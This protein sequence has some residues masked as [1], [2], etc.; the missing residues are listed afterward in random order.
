[1]AT[2]SESTA[3]VTEIVS[4]TT[5]TLLKSIHE[6]NTSAINEL[7]QK[8]AEI[9]EDASQQNSTYGLPVRNLI[10]IIEK[11]NLTHEDETK[12]LSIMKTILRKASELNESEAPLLLTVCDFPHLMLDACIDLLSCL[13]KCKLCVR[14]GYLNN[15]PRQDYD[16]LLN[17]KIIEISV[18]NKEIAALRSINVDQSKP[19][20]VFVQKSTSN[21][22]DGCLRFLNQRGILKFDK[23]PNAFL[24]NGAPNKFL[25]E[26]KGD[27][28]YLYNRS[29]PNTW[30]SI[31]FSGYVI[32]PTAYSLRGNHYY[33]GFHLVHWVFEGETDN[34]EWNLLHENSNSVLPFKETKTFPVTSDKSFKAFRITQKGKNSDFILR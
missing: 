6:G 31:S 14:I 30:F 33:T 15:L 3:T 13:T 2:T 11:S 25:E 28:H 16:Y 20:P 10:S 24:G 19:K 21:V 7:E 34:G 12:S 5:D 27:D 26:P 4:Q 9:I 29:T 17:E 18:L 23:D 32:R 1:M 22:M 8:L